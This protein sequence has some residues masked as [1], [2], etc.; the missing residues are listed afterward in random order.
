MNTLDYLKTLKCDNYNID[1]TL[2]LE[3]DRNKLQL[4]FSYEVT[5]HTY[6]E[7]IHNPKDLLICIISDGYGNFQTMVKS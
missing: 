5:L 1:Y 2:P 3:I 6:E 7:S 4:N